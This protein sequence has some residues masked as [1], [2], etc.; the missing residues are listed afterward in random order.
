[1]A[2][3]PHR[4]RDTFLG[5]FVSIWIF[6][7]RRFHCII[8]G[9]G[10]LLYTDI[11]NHFGRR[12]QRASQALGT[13]FSR[14]YTNQ[15]RVENILQFY[16]L[17]QL[18][19]EPTRK[20]YLLDL[21]ISDISGASVQV[22]PSIADHNAVMM[23]LKLPE[24]LEIMV[25]RTVW[26]LKEAAWNLLQIELTQVDWTTLRNGTAEDALQ[27]FQ[28]IFWTLLIKYIPRK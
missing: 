18:V 19:K 15:H 4:Y 11:R 2:F 26:H 25:P 17:S 22:L 21:V 7:L 5:Q 3:H 10:N 9:N 23:R 6:R 8:F 27:Y 12:S 1:M 20:E 24:I 14:R 28:D 13:I 16:G